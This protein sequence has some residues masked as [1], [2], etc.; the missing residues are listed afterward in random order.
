MINYDTVDVVMPEAYSGPMGCAAV[1]N[2]VR[3][4]PNDW[5]VVGDYGPGEV[6]RLLFRHLFLPER[7]DLKNNNRAPLSV[8]TKH[9]WFVA[10]NAKN[11]RQG[12]DGQ[13]FAA[14]YSIAMIGG[15]ANMWFM[16][17]FVSEVAGKVE[18][19]TADFQLHALVRPNR[20]LS[21]HISSAYTG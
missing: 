2:C 6:R 4:Y 20:L 10:E 1:V 12:D 15:R 13:L 18:A 17:N 19:N 7:Q 11:G 21:A 5:S 16:E 8:G 3:S 9:L 14:S